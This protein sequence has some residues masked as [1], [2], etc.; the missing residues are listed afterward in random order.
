MSVHVSAIMH[1]RVYEL[2]QFQPLAH[3]SRDRE[4]RKLKPAHAHLDH[5]H[6][7]E[8]RFISAA[9]ALLADVSH[10]HIHLVAAGI[11]S[12][13]VPWLSRFMPV[14][15]SRGIHALHSARPP[16]SLK[17]TTTSYP[18]AHCFPIHVPFKLC[19]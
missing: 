12:C 1:V 9:P 4:R 7:H 14:D 19:R 15:A 11:P 2:L 6:K 16:A 17:L 18:W 13:H 8:P 5:D 10:S 3:E